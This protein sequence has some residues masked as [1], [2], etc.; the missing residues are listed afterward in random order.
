M[1]EGS[2]QAYIV[3]EPHRPARIA[4]HFGARKGGGAARA[5]E[6]VEIIDSRVDASNGA[7]DVVGCVRG[8]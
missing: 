1:S 4:R 5:G 3:D 7:Y 8:A 2:K 6:R